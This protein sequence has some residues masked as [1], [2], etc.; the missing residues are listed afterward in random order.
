MQNNREKERDWFSIKYY[1]IV[2]ILILSLGFFAC[3]VEKEEEGELPDIDVEA[4]TGNLPEYEVKKTEEGELPSMDV[5]YE[6]GKLPEYDFDFADVDVGMTK[7][8]VKVPKLVVVMEEH[9]VSVPYIDIK[10]PDDYDPED[11]DLSKMTEKTLTVEV[12]VPAAGYGIEIEDVYISNNR[13]IVLAELS[14]GAHDPEER[15]VQ[16]VSDRVVINGPDLDVK[17]YIIGTRP[18]GSHNTQYKFIESESSIEDKLE[19][20]KVVYEK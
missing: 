16:R 10:M 7:K 14:D 12:E 6:E 11:P 13:Y 5:D 19:N 4:D 15:N 9:E 8:T 18:E 1:F 17:Y 20:S 2:P 3:N